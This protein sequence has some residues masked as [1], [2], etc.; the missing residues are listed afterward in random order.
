M[1]LNLSEVALDRIAD[2]LDVL[3]E[4]KRHELKLP[5]RND[6]AD[7]PDIL[8]LSPDD[9]PDA[10][11]ISFIDDARSADLEDERNNK[12]DTGGAAWAGGVGTGTRR[13]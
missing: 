9:D 3:I 5:R 11:G 7:V 1:P 13:T 2:A 4:L 8:G 10:L 12:I 6:A